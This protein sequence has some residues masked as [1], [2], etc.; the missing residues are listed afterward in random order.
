MT[1]LNKKGFTLIEL[2]IVVAV[3][4]ILAAIAIPQYAR[5]KSRANKAVVTTDARH[6][7]ASVAN[8]FEINPNAVANP[9]AIKTGPG[10]LSAD[11]PGVGVSPSITIEVVSG[12]SKSFK[13]IATHSSMTGTYAISS[14][15]DIVSTLD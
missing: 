1:V 6:A 12:D 3:I 14:N 11:Y 4:G 5:F 10:Q 8:Y 2:L 7:W 13:I 15:G 9:A